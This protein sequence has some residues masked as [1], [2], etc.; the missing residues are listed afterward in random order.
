MMSLIHLTGLSMTRMIQI[1]VL[2]ICIILRVHRTGHLPL[3][4]G[5]E[6][7]KGLRTRVAIL[8]K[9]W[10]INEATGMKMMIPIRIEIDTSS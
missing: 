1:G 4:E 9:K 10:W 6:D 7:P 3:H 8:I 2:G 5:K